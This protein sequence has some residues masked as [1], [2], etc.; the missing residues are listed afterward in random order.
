MKWSGQCG[1]IQF[2]LSK[3]IRRGIE[4]WKSCDSTS[5]YCQEFEIYLG[6]FHNEQSK[7]GPIFDTVWSLCRN[8]AGKDHRIYVDNY[9]SSVQLANFLYSK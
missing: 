8:I 5:A 7:F 2:N 1:Y 9:F 4:I 6:K 3:P